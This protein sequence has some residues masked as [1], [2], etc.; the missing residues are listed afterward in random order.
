MLQSRNTNGDTPG[1]ASTLRAHGSLYSSNDCEIHGHN[2]TRIRS[3]AL[4]GLS[5]LMDVVFFCLCLL[6]FVCICFVYVRLL[7]VFELI[8]SLCEIIRD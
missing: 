1:V 6:R 2:D 4:S 5:V 3:F 8:V 7:S